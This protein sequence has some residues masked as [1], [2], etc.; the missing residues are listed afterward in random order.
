MSLN[1]KLNQNNKQG[2]AQYI[3][4]NNNNNNKNGKNL[5]T[6]MLNNNK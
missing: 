5:K 4:N 3:V 1:Q 2:E 6:N